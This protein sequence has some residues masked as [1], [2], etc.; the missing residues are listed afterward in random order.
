[1]RGLFSCLEG[2]K[3][4]GKKSK[5]FLFSCLVEKKVGGKKKYIYEMTQIPSYNNWKK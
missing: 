2:E 5:T 4:K 1:M 3:I